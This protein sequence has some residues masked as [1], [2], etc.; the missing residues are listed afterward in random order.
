MFSASTRGT[1]VAQGYHRPHG[2]RRRA[3][4]RSAPGRGA[5][6]PRLRAGARC[7]YCAACRTD[8]AAGAARA[9]RG[10]RES[11]RSTRTRP[12]PGKRRRAARTSSSRRAPRAG[13]A[14]PSTCPCSPRSPTS[15]SSAR[16]TSIRRR[17]WR[18]TRSARSTSSQVKRVR[19]AIY[20]GDTES[21]RRWQIRKW[22]NLI[23][24]NPDMLHVGVLPHHDRWG[25]VPLEPPLRRRRRGA[26]LPRRLRLARRQRAA[27]AAAAG[28][29]LRLRSAVPARLGDDRQ[30]RR[31]RELADRPRLHA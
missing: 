21:E 19:P 20:D 23:L 1:P 14:S 22:S 8:L 5:R 28:A 31:A 25:D 26:R 4:G 15:R 27:A 13:R 12:R 9:A 11:T 29:R 3:L 18:R 2:R 10:P 6:V 7:R 24:T 16:S 17:R 30:P